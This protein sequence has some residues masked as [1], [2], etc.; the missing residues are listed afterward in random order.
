MGVIYTVFWYVLGM[1]IPD[2]LGKVKNESLGVIFDVLFQSAV[3]V[4][5]YSWV[6]IRD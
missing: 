2:F 5:V 4:I 3:R 1:Y 6:N